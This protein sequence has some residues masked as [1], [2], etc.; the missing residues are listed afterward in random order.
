MTSV[1]CYDPTTEICFKFTGSSSF[2]TQCAV[3]LCG[4]EEVAS[5]SA[6]NSGTPVSTCANRTIAA[7]AGCPAGTKDT[8]YYI[9]PVSFGGDPKAAC[10]AG[11][12]TWTGPD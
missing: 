6:A 7:V 11:G 4:G 1:S 12:G 2:N 3:D 10:N 5:C 9:S 8:N